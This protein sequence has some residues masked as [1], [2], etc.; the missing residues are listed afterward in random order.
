MTSSQQPRQTLR[1]LKACLALCGKLIAALAVAAVKWLKQKF[2]RLANKVKKAKIDSETRKQITETFKRG[3]HNAA[4]YASSAWTWVRGIKLGAQHF[5]LVFF[6]IVGVLLIIKITSPRGEQHIVSEATTNEQPEE[7]QNA[8]PADRPKFTN[9]TSNIAQHALYTD[10]LLR[11]PHVLN[12]DLLKGSEGKKHKIYSVRSYTQAFPD[13]NDLQLATAQQLG[14]QPVD[15]R[16][17][18]EHLKK[19]LVYIGF[20]PYYDVNTLHASIPYLIPK[21]QLLLEK[22]ARNF[23]D[24]QYVKHVPPSKLLVTSVTRTQD[25]I[26]RLSRYNTNATQNSCHAYGTTFDISYLRY[27][28]LQD[29]NLPPVRPTRNDTLK[30]IL[31]EVLNDLRQQGTCYVKYEG[32]QSCFHITVR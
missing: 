11:L 22:I 32:K 16:Q 19:D 31:S 27:V 18:A 28:P 5:T 10:S 2:R 15:N 29:P 14:I 26:R 23:L 9:F 7:T 30:Y 3:A 6:I 1:D 20:N 13:I 17:T 4:H 12:N 8:E 25:D 21:A 24:S